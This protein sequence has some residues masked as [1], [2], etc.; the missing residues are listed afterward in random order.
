[1]DFD[2]RWGVPYTERPCIVLI[3]QLFVAAVY[4]LNRQQERARA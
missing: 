3:A 1:M 4:D 2:Q